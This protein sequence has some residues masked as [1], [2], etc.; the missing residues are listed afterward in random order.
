MHKPFEERNQTD[1]ARRKLKSL[2]DTSG[3]D[4]AL[5]SALANFTWDYDP[6]FGSEAIGWVDN[7]TFSKAANQQLHSI[8]ETLGLRLDFE[9]DRDQAVKDLIRVHGDQ[10]PDMVWTNFCVAAVTKN[11]GRVSEF[12]SHNYLRGLNDSRAS[13]L[14]WSGKRV[15][16]IEIAR[17]LFLKLF[18]GGTME[19][20]NLGY[21]WCDLTLSLNYANP[22]PMTVT[23]WI[24]QL[25]ASID[26]LPQSSGLQ[27]LVGCCKGHV[28]GDKHF[29]QEVLQAL[30]YSDILRVNGLPVTK[31]FIAER[32]DELSSHFYSNE[33]SFP[34]RFWSEKGGAVNRAAI[35]TH[36]KA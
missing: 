29:K 13:V 26:S 33:W 25:L 31:T 7:K 21:L 15:G 22:K 5:V 20:Q 36:K 23:P 30:A 11:Y 2:A 3:I 27:D 19:R 17:N 10:F 9:L 12:A 16:L 24:D 32:R 1:A 28:G 8:A 18:R 35:P 6:K 4:I 14:E 34:L